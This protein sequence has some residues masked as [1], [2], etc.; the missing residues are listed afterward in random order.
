MIIRKWCNGDIERVFAL[1]KEC[2]TDGWSL[3]NFE[4]SFKNPTFNLLVAEEN[5][6]ILGYGAVTVVADSADIENVAV[7]NSFRRGG[8]GSQILKSLLLLA[9]EKGADKVFLEVRV[10]NSPAMLMYLKHGFVGAYARARYYPDGE[11]CLVMR[12]DLT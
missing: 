4:S 6:E 7:G 12:K 11:D 5:G 9:K 2:F 10:S 1:E 3:Q 8:V